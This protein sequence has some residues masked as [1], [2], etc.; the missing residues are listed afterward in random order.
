VSKQWERFHVA[1]EVPQ[2]VTALFL[3]LPMNTHA[4][5]QNIAILSADMYR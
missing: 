3:T 4:L 2:T 1:K 5:T